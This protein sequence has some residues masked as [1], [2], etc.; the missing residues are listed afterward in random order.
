MQQPPKPHKNARCERIRI[1]KSL[2]VHTQKSTFLRPQ[3]RKQKED[4]IRRPQT[5][6][7][8]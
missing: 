6:R 3:E 5:Q 2:P 1:N 4:N 7:K 8:Q